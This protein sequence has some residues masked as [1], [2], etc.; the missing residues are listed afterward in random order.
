MSQC[1]CKA[2]SFPLRTGARRYPLQSGFPSKREGMTTRR[3]MQLNEQTAG[4]FCRGRI[5]IPVSVGPNMVFKILNV[6]R[7]QGSKYAF[8]RMS[9]EFSATAQRLT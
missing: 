1:C 7:A 6:Q 3:C 8:N 2:H 5:A 4:T 9:A